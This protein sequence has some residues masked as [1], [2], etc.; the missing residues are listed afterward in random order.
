MGPTRH[1]LGQSDTTLSRL[2]GATQ[3]LRINGAPL[4][5]TAFKW[6]PAELV[7]QA[8]AVGV[9]WLQANTSVRMVPAESQILLVVDLHNRGSTPQPLNVSFEIPFVSRLY[10]EVESGYEASSPT[11]LTPGAGCVSSVLLHESLN[12]MVL[13]L[14]CTLANSALHDPGPGRAGRAM[15]RTGPSPGAAL[16]GATGATALRC[17][18]QRTP[19]RQTRSGPGSILLAGPARPRRSAPKT[20]PTRRTVSASR[21]SSLPRSALTK[22]RIGHAPRPA[23]LCILVQ[24]LSDDIFLTCHIILV[25]TRP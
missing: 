23:A 12:V 15:S 18:R 8:S 14:P 10:A 16:P 1:F 21:R 4:V 11:P 9:P 5:S 20:W 25:A 6:T 22:Q 3:N 17:R 19:S 2:Q 24:L 7:R 13:W